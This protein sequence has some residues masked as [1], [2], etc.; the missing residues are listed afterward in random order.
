MVFAVNT[1]EAD[2]VVAGVDVEPRPP[3]VPRARADP[4]PRPPHCVMH[5]RAHSPPEAYLVTAGVGAEPRPPRDEPRP[6]TQPPCGAVPDGA[7]PAGDEPGRDARPGDD[8]GEDA[9]LTGT[10]GLTPPGGAGLSSSGVPPEVPGASLAGVDPAS[11]NP[12]PRLVV[13]QICSRSSIADRFPTT[14]PTAHSGESE[15]AELLEV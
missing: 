13:S 10:G 8:T 12:R 15:S 3:R 5:P 9:S 1:L 4:L 14:S 2:L 7:E 11:A 6:R